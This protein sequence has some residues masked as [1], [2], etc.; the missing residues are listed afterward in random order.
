MRLAPALLAIVLVAAAICVVGVRLGQT[1]PA[2]DAYPTRERWALSDFRG[3][4]YVPVVA[5][6]AG[7]NP[8]DLGRYPRRHHV[9]PFP[10]YAP[11]LLAWHLPFGFFSFTVARVLYFVL[12]LVLTVLIARMS[13]QFA[14][15]RPSWAATFALASLVLLSR[16]GL[17]A[18]VL[19]QYSVPLTLATYV[20]FARG[21]S[22]AGLAA[23]AVAYTTIKPTFSLPLSILLL[24]RGHGRAVGLGLASS[25][26]V[27]IPV[28]A[29]LAHIAGGFGPLLA[30]I[31]ADATDFAFRSDVAAAGNPHRVDAASVFAH[32]G[33]PLGRG[34]I[35][36]TVVVI[37]LGC[38]AVR[39]LARESDAEAVS[40]STTIA[41][42]TLLLCV[43]HNAYDLVLLVAPLTL[44]VT[45]RW[46]SAALR[47]TVLAGLLIP[48]VNFA[49][50][51]SGLQRLGLTTASL[52]GQL[53]LTV[54]GVAL[55]VVFLVTVNA[56]LRRRRVGM[57]EV[58]PF[59][60]A[61]VE[62][63]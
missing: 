9:D 22:H 29:I 1:L 38:L 28:V 55:L 7:E 24:C 37:A 20:A 46:C 16:P 53:V 40:L 33:V 15:D 63:V 12:C 19:G 49:A 41:C 42:L 31:R 57:C 54:N 26:L 36:L 8:Y 6:L 44:A 43:Y 51:H 47:W 60:C 52:V 2:A 39:R 32:V 62:A 10:P 27:S 4:L 23:A 58:R 56:A 61:R 5:F 35:V 21:G 25:A 11:V 59:P 30:S 17:W 18:T 14:R 3:N 50:T 48:F 13:L 34:E 45:G